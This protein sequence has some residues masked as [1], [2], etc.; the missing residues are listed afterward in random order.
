MSHLL[1]VIDISFSYRNYGNRALYLKEKLLKPQLSRP[2][3]TNLFNNLNFSASKGEV[4]SFLGKNGTGKSTLLKLLSGVYEPNTGEISRNGIICP[5]IELGAA[6]HNELSGIENMK[7][8]AAFLGLSDRLSN[9]VRDEI[10]AW[11]GLDNYIKAPVRTYSSGM[12]A[13]LAFALAIKLKPDI[14]ILDEVL[15][16]GD[17]DFRDRARIEV[18]DYVNNGGTVFLVSHDLDLVHDLSSRLFILYNHTFVEF[19]DVRQGIEKYL[20]KSKS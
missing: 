17:Q 20:H 2:V 19:T 14:L 15:S 16:V 5:L 4:I 13:R 10:I 3:E 11:S 12:V 9:V 18:E 1:N 8:F 7:M 6:F